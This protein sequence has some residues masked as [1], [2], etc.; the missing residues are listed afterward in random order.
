MNTDA[1]R[2]SVTERRPILRLNHRREGHGEPVLAQAIV[3]TAEAMTARQAES[4][5]SEYTE[6]ERSA[7][8]ARLNALLGG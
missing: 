3:L 7:M 2:A 8:P 4:I 6:A 5:L 1:A